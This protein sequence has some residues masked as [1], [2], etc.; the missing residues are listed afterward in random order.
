MVPSFSNKRMPSVN[1]ISPPLPGIVRSK[2]S[3]IL[4][5][6]IYR[7]AKARVEGVVFGDGFSITSSI[8]RRIGY[9]C[10]RIQ[11]FGGVLVDRLSEACC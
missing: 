11:G 4:A 7:A 9:S 8:S 1:W 3:K 6:R 2:A 10:L 5:G